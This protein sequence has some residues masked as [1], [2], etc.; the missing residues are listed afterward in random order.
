MIQKKN[1]NN[2]KNIYQQRLVSV[3]YFTKSD[4]PAVFP[5]GLEK[6]V[7]IPNKKR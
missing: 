7:S 6:T 3:Y 1:G 4:L 5:F 2:A